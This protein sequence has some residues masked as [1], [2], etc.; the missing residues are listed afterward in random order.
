[1]IGVLECNPDRIQLPFNALGFKKACWLV[2]GND[3]FRNGVKTSDKISVDLKTLKVGQTVGLM[4]DST[5]NLHVIVEGMDNVIAT[6]VGSRCRALVVLYGEAEQITILGRDDEKER[7]KKQVSEKELIVGF[8]KSLDLN[9]NKIC[10]YLDA[11]MRFKASL[12][13]PGITNS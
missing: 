10:Y 5:H 6:N 7:S 13:I 1:M 11:C 8:S 2:M 4:V 12:V 9:T 3:V